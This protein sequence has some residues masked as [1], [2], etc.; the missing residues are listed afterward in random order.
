M[1]ARVLVLACGGT[2]SSTPGPNG[3][4][5]QL[6]AHDL[7]EELRGGASLRVTSETHS[8]IAS[9]DATMA[10]AVAIWQRVRQWSHTTPG[11]A[12]V[13]THGTD[14][15]EE[16]AFAVEALGVGP[17]PVVFTGAMRY[18]GSLGADG[19]ANLR[20]AISVAT[21][22]EAAD[23]G[24][25]VVFNDEIHLATRVRKSHTSNV[26]TFVS[27]GFGPIGYVHEGQARV[28]LRPALRPNVAA[29]TRHADE[30]QV[31]LISVGAGDDGRLLRYVEAAGYAG[32]VIEGL[33]GGHLPSRLVASDGLAELVSAMPVVVAS[34]CGAG[35]LLQHTYAFPGSEQDLARRGLINAGVLDATKA[36][37]LLVLLIASQCREGQLRSAFARFG[38]YEQDGGGSVGRSGELRLPAGQR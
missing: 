28:V 31:A 13:V 8:L 7:V 37:V 4:M 23:M 38:G 34:R 3:A 27:P 5:P 20:S 22:P 6:E 35:E 36:R 26:A 32:A 33:G 11:G 18:A 14:T 29:P 1:T 2:I 16:I 30:V 24:V 10:D 19:G 15:M 17:T 12:V 25:L 21:S 9:S